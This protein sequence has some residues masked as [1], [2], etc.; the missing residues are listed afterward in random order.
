VQ[1]RHQLDMWRIT[2]VF[3]EASAVSLRARDLMSDGLP[4]QIEQ[5]FGQ[6]ALG[7]LYDLRKGMASAV[8]LETEIC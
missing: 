1:F 6:R 8:G 4:Q 2:E 3:I 7:M 5:L